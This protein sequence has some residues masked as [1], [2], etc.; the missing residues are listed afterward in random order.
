MQ[1]ARELLNLEQPGEAINTLRL[2]LGA[3][4]S[5]AD[6][7]DLAREAL[8]REVRA[9]IQSAVRQEEIIEARQLERLRLQQA[10]TQRPGVSPRSCPTSRP[11]PR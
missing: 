8:R 1:H 11:S 9:E 2:A 5:A 3:I 4:D 7:P 10:A 6:V